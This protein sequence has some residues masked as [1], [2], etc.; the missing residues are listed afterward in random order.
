MLVKPARSLNRL[1]ESLLNFLYSD[2]T[3]MIQKYS[4]RE[5]AG[6]LLQEGAQCPG[7]DIRAC[8]T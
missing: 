3:S 7:D 1:I 2:L 5:G 4:R 8:G 6:E